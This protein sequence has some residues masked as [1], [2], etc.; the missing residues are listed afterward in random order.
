M[1][2][3]EQSPA[4]PAVIFGDLRASLAFLTRLPAGWLGVAADEVPN[5]KRAAGL[6]PLA[7]ALVGL[8]GG[9]VLVVAVAI[10]VPPLAAATLAV[11]A[12]V[13]LTGGLHEDGL[14]DMADS[15]GGATREK[16]LAI[17]DDSRLGTF[18]VTALALTLI[19]RV[20]CLS[21]IAG[22]GAWR[23]ALV[24][25]VAEGASRA[26]LVSM[27]HAL[28]PARASGLAHDTGPPDTRAMTVALALAGALALAAIPV[29]GAF[30]AL[31]AAVFAALAAYMVERLSVRAIGG[32]TGDTLGA[33]QQLVLAAY[34]VGAATL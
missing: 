20:A 9:A 25:I 12:T 23:A 1:S 31:L 15:L 5:F 4:D 18:G 16:R 10:G 26:A 11:I 24:L 3:K 30:A 7:G 13:A 17:L 34:L 29:V 14:A 19:L 33:C 2:N 21:A 27:W 22:H 28:P 32:R 8:A 6:F